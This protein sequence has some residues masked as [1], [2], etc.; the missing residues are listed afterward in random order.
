MAMLVYTDPSG[1][2]LTVPLGPDFP[3]VSIGRATECTIRSNRK[4]VSRRHA[5]FHY[6]NGRYEV[7]DLGSS[8]GTYLI[9]NDERK[10]VV[11]P[12]TLAHSDE[13]WCGDFILR[14]YEDDAMGVGVGGG[15]SSSSDA[16]HQQ[17][18][19]F[20]QPNDYQP[21]RP[22][23][24]FGQDSDSGAMGSGV[25]GNFNQQP[26]SGLHQ[27]PTPGSGGVGAGLGGGFSEG[28]SEEPSF[29]FDDSPQ[30]FSAAAD[31]DELQRL[32]D[33]KRSIEDLAARQAQ[34][35]DDLRAQLAQGSNEGGG[36]PEAVERLSMELE[37]AQR[38]QDRLADE[39]RMT[40]ETS[41]EVERERE[42]AVEAEQRLEE[43]TAKIDE[44]RQSLDEAGGDSQRVG[45][46]TE[47]LENRDRDLKILESELERS[48]RELQEA[49]RNAGSREELTELR[50]E[51]QRQERLLG[52]YEK[53][54]RDLQGKVDQE[55]EAGQSL[56]SLVQEYE[57]KIDELEGVVA[58][59]DELLKEV[60]SLREDHEELQGLRSEIEGL[61]QRLR[62]EK[63]RAQGSD[64]ES[65][66]EL[67][68]EIESL[69][70]K[71]ATAQDGMAAGVA[72]AELETLATHAR[73]LDRVIDAIERT[74]LSPLSTVDRVR[75]QSAIRDT[76]P[77]QTLS[78][79][80]E[81][82]EDPA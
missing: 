3:V 80:L 48:E 17:N 28:F 25:Q 41:V 63:Q 72:G 46:L 50:E 59:R 75:L 6:T 81:I 21:N 24:N 68:E 31:N 26:Q 57:E 20:Q 82:V 62:L 61:K 67:Q 56:R 37:A 54:N 12:E 29:A 70:A 79:M 9:I 51:V 22:T 11:Q 4:S 58:E 18:N 39:L 77:R 55:I 53:R 38:E 49:R 64:S 1:Q 44:L 36:D 45:E 30:D 2:E 16:F 14:F 10:P 40:Q 34:E 8:N 66:E 74:D 60:Q 73:T 15:L 7:V 35:L 13:V 52:E 71:L 76:K 27:G 23:H 42:R 33:E 69:K 19:Q 78:E 32:R 5:E 65:V 47:E 43:A